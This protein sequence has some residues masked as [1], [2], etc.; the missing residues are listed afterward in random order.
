[1]NNINTLPTKVFALGGLG[2]VGKNMYVV[3][4]DSKIF[5]FD[6]GLK[7]ADDKLLGVD[8]IIPN[9]DY[10]IT[11]KTKPK[12]EYTEYNSLTHHKNIATSKNRL[13]N[14][15]G[16]LKYDVAT[17][18]W[19]EEWRMPTKDEMLELVTVCK[20][21]KDT[22]LNGKQGLKIIGPNGNSIF[23]PYTCI[24]FEKERIE[25]SYCSFWT[26]SA[27]E[28]VGLSY[29]LDINDRVITSCRYVGY[30]IRAVRS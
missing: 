20:L 18:N 14:I 7:Y 9:Y 15:S 16:K 5:V 21:E 28:G 24:C 23:L 8:Y 26:S 2:E 13:W 25:K 27:F 19:G 3:E 30:A 4:V 6:A 1:M 12:D 11:H 22:M 10:L 17:A 29:R